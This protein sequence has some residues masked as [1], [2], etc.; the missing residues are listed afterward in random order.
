[1]IDLAL[2]REDVDI[3]ILREGIRA[4]RRFVSA[5]AWSGYTLEELN[6]AQTDDELDFWAR[7]TADTLYH[8]VS[9]AAMSPFNATWGVV[10]PDLRVKGVQGLR[11]VDAS[12]MASSLAP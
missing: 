11:I 6:P 5:P 1:L 8:P 9:T 10:D 4:A 12:V 3:A 7:Q 2:L